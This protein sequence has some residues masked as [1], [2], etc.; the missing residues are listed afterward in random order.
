MAMLPDRT[1]VR[2][3]RFFRTSHFITLVFSDLGSS[4]M[5]SGLRWENYGLDS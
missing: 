1:D 2:S 4:R 3:L 5:R